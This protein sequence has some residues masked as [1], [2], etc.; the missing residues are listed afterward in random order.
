[1][2]SGQFDGGTLFLS[3]ALS[4]YVKS[5]HRPKIKALFPKARFAK[6]PN[7]GHWLHAE[8]A[9]GFEAAVRVFLGA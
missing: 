5:E 2:E 7:A 8:D 9:R 4:D 1:N 6:L 3:G